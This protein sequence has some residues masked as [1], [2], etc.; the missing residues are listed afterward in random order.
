MKKAP[1][2]IFDLSRIVVRAARPRRELRPSAAAK[3]KTPVA[4]ARRSGV[5][6]R[7]DFGPQRRTRLREPTPQGFHAGESSMVNSANG[8]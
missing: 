2:M 1:R 3:R 8:G 6:D 7:N 5:E 4:L